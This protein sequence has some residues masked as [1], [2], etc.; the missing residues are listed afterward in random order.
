MLRD[1]EP[2]VSKVLVYITL[3]FWFGKCM[4]LSRNQSWLQL[5]RS[6]LL[7]VLFQGQSSSLSLLRSSKV[8]ERNVR[9]SKIV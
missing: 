5:P 3:D 6:L 2:T 7:P 8:E 4:E 1:E 9:R